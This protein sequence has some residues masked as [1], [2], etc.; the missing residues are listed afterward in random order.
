MPLTLPSDLEAFADEYDDM[1]GPAVY[2][3]D[4]EPPVDVPATWDGNFDHRPEYWERLVHA[5]T[6]VYV[7]AASNVL[8]R[9]EEHRDGDVRKAIL[10]SIAADCSLRNVWWCMSEIEA[11]E[12]E[13]GIAIRLGN[14]LPANIYVHQR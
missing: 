4:L 6:W 2:A 5:E 13:S 8:R 10:P 7:G 14:Y 12:R 3:L 11:F 9:L 1:T